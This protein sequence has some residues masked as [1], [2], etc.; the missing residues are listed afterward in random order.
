MCVIH[1][2][3]EFNTRYFQNVRW[4]VAAVDGHFG[5]LVYYSVG[6]NSSKFISNS[7]TKIVKVY[8]KNLYQVNYNN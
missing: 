5:W 2:G 3:K 1:E 6:T 8:G 7:Y 4:A